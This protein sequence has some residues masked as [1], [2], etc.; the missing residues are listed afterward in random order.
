M[1][2]DT[3]TMDLYNL[4]TVSWK[5][6]QLLYHALPRLGR[7]GLILLQPASPYVCLGFHQD[8]CQEIDIA[9]LQAEEIPLFRR[10]V[11]GGAVYLD[12]GQ[13][14][15]Q[16]VLRAD[17]VPYSKDAFYRKY[18]EPVV[19]T[20]RALGLD[21]QFKPVNDIVIR[22]RK[23]SG[24]GAAEIADHAV[25]VGNILIDFDYEMMARVLR[26]PDEK[27]RDKVY[28]TLEQNLTTLKREL[29]DVPRLQDLSILLAGKFEN[30]LGPL[31]PREVDPLLRA[32]ASRLWRR[33]GTDEW[34]FANDNR[35]RTSRDL[36][37]A[38]GI[39]VVERLYKSPGGLIRTSAVE[40]DGRLYQ[41]HISGDFFMFPA[42]GLLVLEQVLEGIP[43]D[44]AQ[45]EQRITAFV[46]AHAVELPGVTPSDLAQ[47]LINPPCS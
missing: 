47:T 45:I 35:R 7:E 16:L 31:T 4:G 11:G 12:S 18:L 32:E 28:Q 21:A 10:E 34:T 27:F 9:T 26:V 41:I 36:T 24:N 2:A 46:D 1:G 39:R 29:A 14:F 3:L 42:Q 13:L 8:A 38:A 43:A 19:E 6:S 23:L 25:L 22:G 17:R 15:Y 44:V 40:R 30:L 33:F 5:N 37:I 20:L